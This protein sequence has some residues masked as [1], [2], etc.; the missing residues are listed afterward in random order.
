MAAKHNAKLLQIRTMAEA[1]NEIGR[2]GA[3]GESVKI[4]APKCLFH[5][6]RLEKIRCPVANILKQ[7]MLSAGGDAA[8]SEHSVDCSTPSTDVLLMG[9]LKQYRVLL[10]KMRGQGLGIKN[11]AEYAKK[12][13]DYLTLAGEI[14]T[15][16]KTV[17]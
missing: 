13:A 12:Y 14:E 11:K 17:G 8:V 7:E 6:M 16:L 4:M 9:T 1:E 10:G 3:S 15:V 2:T 5:A